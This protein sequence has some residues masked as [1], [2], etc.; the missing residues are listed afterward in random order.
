MA[1]RFLIPLSDG[2]WLALDHDTFM[3]ALASGDELTRPAPP[4]RKETA[5]ELLTATQIADRLKVPRSWIE[6]ATREGRLPYHE[7][8]RYRR[9]S[10]R[11][12][13][14]ATKRKGRTET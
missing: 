1:N 12:V 6:A 9:Y 8:G 3:S 10:L 7:F 13:A 14:S 11:D 2:R 4:G 5:D